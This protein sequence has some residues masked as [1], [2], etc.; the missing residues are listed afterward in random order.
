MKQQMIIESDDGDFLCRLIDWLNK[1][2]KAP[3]GKETRIIFQNMEEI[4][5]EFDVDED[6]DEDR[7][8]GDD[9]EAW[10]IQDK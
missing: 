10:R 4:P 1:Q 5:I 9:L 7:Q 6:E 3:E 2:P 8:D